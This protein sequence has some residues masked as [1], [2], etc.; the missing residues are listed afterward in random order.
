MKNL[1]HVV[2]VDKGRHARL[3]VKENPDF[4]HALTFNLASISLGELSACAANYPLVFVRNPDNQNFRP[5]AM[6]GLRP[7]ENVYY[8]AEGWDCTYIPLMVQR[9][10]FLI[11]FDDLD[12]DSRTLATCLDKNSTLLSE[13]EGIALFTDTG[14]D[15]DYL[16]TRKNLLGAIFEG[17]KITEQFTQKMTELNLFAPFELLL[18]PQNGEPRKVTGMY[19][20]DERKI[21]ELSPE[22][23]QELHKLDFLPACYIIMSSLFQVHHL[24]ALRN[25]KSGE[26]ANYRI[27]LQPQA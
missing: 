17:E 21:R 26:L 14:E 24:M 2:T 23:V 10:P 22:Q 3:R 25:R 11:G 6:F 7:G 18:Q 12:E 13:D 9:H 4:R 27:E 16:K 19:T 5:V 8:G 15:T 20:L 1:D